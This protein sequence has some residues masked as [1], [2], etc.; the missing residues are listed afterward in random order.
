MLIGLSEGC[1]RVGDKR[2]TGEIDFIGLKETEGVVP[3]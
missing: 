2:Q 1:E 3:Y